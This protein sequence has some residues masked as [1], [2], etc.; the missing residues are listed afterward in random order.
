MFLLG[1]K[2]MN[3]VTEQLALNLNLN[4][5]QTLCPSFSSFGIMLHES[6]YQMG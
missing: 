6:E 2:M 3:Q 5:L 1:V 4:A